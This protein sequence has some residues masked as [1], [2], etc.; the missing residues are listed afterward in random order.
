[1][2]NDLDDAEFW[3]P[4]QILTDDDILMDFAGNGDPQQKDGFNGYDEF[5]STVSGLGFLGPFSDQSSPV[6]S[7][8]GSTEAGSDE[9]DYIGLTRQM[10][11]ST[12]EQD[13]ITNSEGWVSSGSPQSPVC[14]V[15][16]GVCACNHQPSSRGNRNDLSSPRPRANVRK[17]KDA[18]SD[19][20]CAAAGEVGR[21]RVRSEQPQGKG[22]G[23]FDSSRAILYSPAKPIQISSPLPTNSDNSATAYSAALYSKAS[24]RLK[25]GV[26]RGQKWQT[27]HQISQRS[28]ATRDDINGE[29]ARNSS[30]LPS[31]LPLGHQNKHSRL[32][33][34]H[35]GTV[36]RTVF[37]GTP[38][39][40]RETVGTGVFLPRP[41][42][43]RPAAAACSA[44]LVPGKV[45]QALNNIDA[46]MLSRKRSTDPDGAMRILNVGNGF[47][48]QRRSSRP[49]Q[50]ANDCDV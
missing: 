20:T 4:S 13:S 3:L 19:L 2:A 26:R 34:P 8:T 39:T 48:P 31:W 29:Y 36:V 44:V 23:F 12:L 16:G 21:V 10:A 46:A 27:T 18:A 24:R 40:E 41:T 47:Q 50:A 22:T 14:T 30:S 37:S 32:Q 38:R 1:M 49:P 42:V 33:P 17:N 7:V 28:R 25:Q 9:E 35:P 45:V 15:G 6:E 5:A 43:L 11:R